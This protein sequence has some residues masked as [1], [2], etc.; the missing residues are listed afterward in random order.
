MRVNCVTLLVN[1][2][3][4]EEESPWKISFKT[5][6]LDVD[7]SNLIEHEWNCNLI[8]LKNSKLYEGKMWS[9]EITRDPTL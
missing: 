4:H 9:S 1:K 2:Q 3:M 8:M 6:L 5:L 7:L